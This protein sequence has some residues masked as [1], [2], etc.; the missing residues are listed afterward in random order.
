[1]HDAWFR[2]TA[3]IVI[4]RF[5]CVIHTVISCQISDV[6]T[7]NILY[8]RLYRFFSNYSRAA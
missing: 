5:I 6:E 8:T 1:M 2:L 7:P 3:P 4:W